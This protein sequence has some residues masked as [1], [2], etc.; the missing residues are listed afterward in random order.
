MVPTVDQFRNI[1]VERVNLR[2]VAD[3]SDLLQSLCASGE[4]FLSE[5]GGDVTGKLLDGRS[6]PLGIERFKEY[7]RCE[8]GAC[9]IRSGGAERR[10]HR[11]EVPQRHHCGS[12]AE[13][14]SVR[15]HVKRTR[16]TIGI[17]DEP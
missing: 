6:Y 10:P 15:A 8:S 17:Y 2:A 11:R 14:A 3:L 12:C 4:A 5:R 1:D 7:E 9:D 13:L 16:A